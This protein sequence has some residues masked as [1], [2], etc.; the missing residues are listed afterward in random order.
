MWTLNK[1]GA[2][3]AGQLPV[4]VQNK[5]DAFQN[6]IHN[7]GLHPKD[8][9]Q[10]IGD[11]N[12]KKLGNSQQYQI[13]LSQAHRVTFLVDDVTHTVTILQVGGHT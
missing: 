12:F 1:Q 4:A 11:S 10:W 7:L 6:A 8:A 13:R 5:F 9:A 3:F 2:G